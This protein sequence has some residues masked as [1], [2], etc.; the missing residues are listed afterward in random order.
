MSHKEVIVEN[1][2]MEDGSIFVCFMCEKEFRKVSLLNEH[3]QM[4]QNMP[5]MQKE[6]PSR[7]GRGRGNA[8]SGGTRSRGRG[9]G[10]GRGMLKPI[11]IKTEPDNAVYIKSE[12]EDMICP[13]T[14]KKKLKGSGIIS[15]AGEAEDGDEARDPFQ[16]MMKRI[17]RRMTQTFSFKMKKS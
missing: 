8:G 6:L 10:R 16:W 12:P 1:D 4:H 9:R 15:K 13:S 17:W 3:M 7:R 14:I 2:E 11:Q 5:E